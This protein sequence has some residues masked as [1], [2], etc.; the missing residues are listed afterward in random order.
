MI[1]QTI[2]VPPDAAPLGP[3]TIHAQSIAA[4][5]PSPEPSQA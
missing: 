4:R 1:R 3:M 2:T 5:Q